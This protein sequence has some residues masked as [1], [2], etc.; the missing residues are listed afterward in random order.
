MCALGVYAG[1]RYCQLGPCAG[2]GCGIPDIDPAGR[3]ASLVPL[4]RLTLYEV[5]EQADGA[6]YGQRFADWQAA[7]PDMRDERGVRL[8]RIAAIVGTRLRYDYDFGD[9]WHIEI[10][11]ESI[12]TGME[13]SFLTD[14]GGANSPA[15]R[16]GDTAPL[17]RQIPQ[18]SVQR[19]I[20]AKMLKTLRYRSY[21]RKA[22]GTKLRA[23]LELCRTLYNA[24]LQERREAYRLGGKSLSYQDQQNELPALKAT[25]PEYRTVHSQVLQDVLQRLDKAFTIRRRPVG[26]Q[27]PGAARRRRSQA[28]L[29]GGARDGRRSRGGQ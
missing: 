29:G 12:N 22:Q 20:R 8:S 17:A 10:V 3:H 28:G 9:S 27:D 11:V 26:I 23:T 18:K 4:P 5:R 21:P 15:L 6:V 24:A 2:L 7:N 1:A 19:A 25:C 13:F 16:H 14:F